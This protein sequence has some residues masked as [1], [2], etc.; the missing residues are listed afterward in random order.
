MIAEHSREHVNPGHKI[1]RLDELVDVLLAGKQS[2]DAYKLQAEEAA[3]LAT[4]M[5]V[6]HG[7]SQDELHAKYD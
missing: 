7:F 5:A 6:A 2:Y 4:P 1:E 3:L